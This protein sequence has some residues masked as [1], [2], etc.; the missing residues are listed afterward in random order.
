MFRQTFEQIN[1]DWIAALKA[2]QER[3]RLL[4]IMAQL[5]V[6]IVEGRR[7][8]IALGV[9][10]EQAQQRLDAW[11][12]ELAKLPESQVTGVKRQRLAELAEAYAVA[13]QAV[14]TCELNVK[15]A[16]RRLRELTNDLIDL[17]ECD[18]A[19]AEVDKARLA[20][21]MRLPRDKV[22]PL[23]E[24]E[25]AV[26][27]MQVRK[28]QVVEGLAFLRGLVDGGDPAGNPSTKQITQRIAQLER[29]HQALVEQ[30][31]QLQAE[32][33]KLVNALWLLTTFD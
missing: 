14:L 23:W 7:A 1:L 13:K 20:L 31:N 25:L 19:Y 30:Q 18:E 22:E 4:D 24:W 28:E 5:D 33:A 10:R 6:Q 29:T 15:N 21:L 2:V 8:V 32:K 3:D 16:R 17:A 27:T 12:A 26:A 11:E 9:Q